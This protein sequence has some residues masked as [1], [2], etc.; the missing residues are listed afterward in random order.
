MKEIKHLPYE[1]DERSNRHHFYERLWKHRALELLARH[2]EVRGLDVLDYGC[3]RG[4][5]LELFGGEGQKFLGWTQTPFASVWRQSLDELSFLTETTRLS[6]LT[7][8]NLMWLWPFMFWS[9]LK[10]RKKH[11]L[12]WVVSPESLSLW[13]CRIS[14]N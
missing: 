3:G 10:I 6:G 4:E 2:T 5:A 12:P 13:R 9:M 7:L 1:V 8:A 11:S 14:G